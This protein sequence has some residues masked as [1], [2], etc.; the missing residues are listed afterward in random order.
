VE[1]DLMNNGL[2][3]MVKCNVFVRDVLIDGSDERIDAE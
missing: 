1:N 3:L 2:S